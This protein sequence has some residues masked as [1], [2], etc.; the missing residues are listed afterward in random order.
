MQGVKE[1]GKSQHNKSK[2]MKYSAIALVVVFLISGA[3]LLLEVWDKQRGTFP[4]IDVS[5]DFIEYEGKEYVLK[6]NVETFLVLG[7]DKFSGSSQADSY[8]ND[9]QADFVMLFV[10]D[11]S[12]RTSSAIHINRDTMVDVNVLGVDGSKVDTTTQQ[13]ALAHTYGN[14]KDASCRNTA[15]SV[16]SLL[17]GMKVNHYISLTV[18]SV[19]TVSDLVG[20]V[21]VTVLDDFTGI[22]DTLVKG[23]TVKLTGEQALR[24]V[25]SRYG[26]ED[27]TNS[28]R[29]KRQQQFVDALVDRL[30]SCIQA[31]DEFVVEASTKMADYIVSDRSVTQL[32]DLMKKF[33]EYEFVGIRS[34]DG[35]SK[36]GEEFMEFYPNDEFIRGLV[37]DLFY[38]E[39]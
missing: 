12:A 15:D 1:M 26:L 11:H 2:V 5:D 8:N 39:K 6:E 22:D 35:E 4:A 36:R 17:Y 32:Q 23:E 18:D 31:D 37:I 28:A 19:A 27:S 33:H 24:Y 20:G 25:R 9:K 3:L 38:K 16:S 13:I 30:V 14:G 7:L 34:I 29:M 21:E 10:L